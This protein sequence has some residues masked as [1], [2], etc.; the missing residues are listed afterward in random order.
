MRSGGGALRCAR[1]LT[2][3]VRC[4]VCRLHNL[5]PSS[6][7]SPHPGCSECLRFPNDDRQVQDWMEGVRSS[8]PASLTPRPHAGDRTMLLLLLQVPDA[9]H[10][11]PRVTA[12]IQLLHRQVH[13]SLVW[14][15]YVVPRPFGMLSVFSSTNGSPCE[16][17]RLMGVAPASFPIVAFS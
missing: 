17:M 1:R 8:A 14:P 5:H 7:C 16:P 11:S 10:L 13:S 6:A 15:C 4:A 9:L 2:R 3:L 12:H